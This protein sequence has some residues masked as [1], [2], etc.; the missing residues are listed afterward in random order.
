MCHLT[1]LTLVL[2]LCDTH[3]CLLN[4]VIDGNHAG[5]GCTVRGKERQRERERF[6]HQSSR[7]HI[8]SNLDQYRYF[9]IQQSDNSGSGGKKKMG[10]CSRNTGSHD[11]N[12]GGLF[13]NNSSLWPPAGISIP[14]QNLLKQS[15]HTHKKKTHPEIRCVSAMNK[16]YKH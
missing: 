8:P 7:S 4:L 1:T 15:I 12:R 11:N 6:N 3:H 13:S 5:T 14:F 16:Y 2:A 9:C 10:E